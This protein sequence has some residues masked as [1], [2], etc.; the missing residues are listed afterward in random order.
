MTNAIGH[1]LRADEKNTQKHESIEWVASYAES[2]TSDSDRAMELF[3]QNTRDK[4]SMYLRDLQLFLAIHTDRLDRLR[5]P[6]SIVK[7][8]SFVGA[9]GASGL[10]LYLSVPAMFAMVAPSLVALAAYID[11]VKTGKY[12][13]G[14]K[15][16]MLQLEKAEIL[17]SAC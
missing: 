10:L 11:W 5:S 14:Y 17:R 8:W 6:F 2:V 13:R 3:Q 15:L 9:M 12:V 1:D 4:P 16:L 7:F